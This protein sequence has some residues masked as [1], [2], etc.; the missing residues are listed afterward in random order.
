MAKKQFLKTTL[1][2]DKFV[3]E[4]DLKGLVAATDDANRMTRKFRRENRNEDAPYNKIT[5]PEKFLKF[6]AHRMLHEKGAFE[7]SVFDCFLFAIHDSLDLAVKK[8]AGVKF[9][10][11]FPGN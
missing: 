6:V 2:R 11:T 8:R 10:D 9:S 3:V 4:L 5:D 7:F 1:T